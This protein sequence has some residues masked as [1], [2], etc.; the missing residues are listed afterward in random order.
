V[1]VVPWAREWPAARTVLPLTR[2]TA[3]RYA[4]VRERLRA[5]G[6][7]IPGNDV[8]IAALAPERGLPLLSRDEHF[9][10]VEGLRRRAW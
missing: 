6:S 3:E 1:D 9:G 8:W 10:R 4:R 2:E 7:P 5:A